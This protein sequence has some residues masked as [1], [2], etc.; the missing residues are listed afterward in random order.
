[1]SDLVTS[2]D[3][4]ELEIDDRP[5]NTKVEVDDSIC[6]TCKV[7]RWPQKHLIQKWTPILFCRFQG[8]TFVGETISCD[9][10]EFWFHWTC[11]GVKPGDDVVIKE[12]VPFYCGKCRPKSKKAKPP[13]VPS[14]TTK[15]STPKSSSSS[16]KS[17]SA[18]KIS[19]RK[20][21][22]GKIVIGSF[23]P[24]SKR[25]STSIYK[26]HDED[27]DVV[28]DTPRSPPI[29]LKISL[30]GK[31]S[32]V[33]T[34]SPQSSTPHGET[35]KRSIK[36]STP[37]NPSKQ[38]PNI[39][40]KSTE[41]SEEEAWLD[42]VESGDMSKHVDPELRSI[43]NPK[44]MTARQRAMVERMKQADDSYLADESN[45]SSSTAADDSLP[46]SQHI[47]LDYK[48]KK[49]KVKEN[50]PDEEINQKIK[51]MKAEKRKEIE[52]EKREEE[53]QKT[54]D[55]L[56]KKS[57][58]KSILRIDEKNQDVKR[59]IPKITYRITE[60]EFSLS[61]PKG[62]SYPIKPKRLDEGKDVPKP[63]ECSIPGCGK[64]K[65]YNCSKSGKP[66]CSLA[67]YKQNQ[68][69]IQAA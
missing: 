7:R 6:P 17:T 48:K 39:M 51:A 8:S 11:E 21:Q 54:V 4:S 68:V 28:P 56:L 2:S 30:G 38:Q 52:L 34:A 1:M 26:K 49:R 50:D 60:N 61:F 66:L 63:V 18:P 24:K 69:L 13:N 23:R 31:S 46:I 64:I 9:K 53:K 62:A 65:R 44:M 19:S 41:R 55:R 47:S 37:A 67:C 35:H 15:S 33:V 42:A 43:K 45:L 32:T 36:F 57:D 29:K 25:Q 22:S 12:D 59:S 58:S 10:C 14:T 27:E 40:N 16:S 3:E 20:G 5:S